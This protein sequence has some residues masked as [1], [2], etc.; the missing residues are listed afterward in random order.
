MRRSTHRFAFF[1]VAL[2][3]LLLAIGMSP[4][5]GA[6]S[7]ALPAGSVPQGS[8]APLNPAFLQSLVEVPIDLPVSGAVGQALG[9]RPGLLDFSYTRGMQVPG[10]GALA[11]PATY[12]LR[13]L[14]RV[15]SVKNQNPYGTC[16]TFGSLGS[17][18]SCLLPGETQD[19]SEDNMVLNH[20]FDSG[21]DPYNRGGNIWMSTAYLTR[22]SGPVYESEDAYGDS[23]TPAGLSPRK[24]VQEVNWIPVRG[25][26]LDNDN[27]KN[28][29]MVYGGADVS[30]GWYGD[31]SGSSY[32]NATTASYYYNGTGGTNHEVLLVGWDDNYAA[33]N[34]ATTPPGNGAFIVKNSWGTA[35]GSGGYFYASYYDTKFGR[36]NNPSAA[37]N[38]AEPTSNYTGLYQYDPLGFAGGYGYSSST[39]WFANVFT[40]QATASLSAVGFY[41]VTPGTSYEVYTG[42]SLATKTLRTS[43]SLS[44]M[45]YHTVTLPTPVA[46]TS[47]QPFVVAV[48]V[49]SP[50]T[51][52]PIAM[53]APYSNYSSTATAQPGQSYVSATG[54]SW[55]D[56]TTSIA[57]ANVC[58]KAYVKTSGGSA[59]TVTGFNP[60]SGPVGTVVTV[61]GTGLL[62]ATSVAFN[63]TAAP[64]FNVISATQITATVPT[65]ATTGTIAVTTPGGTA[66]SSGSFTVTSAAATL[67]VTSPNGGETWPISS[68]QTITW[69]STGLLATS[70]VKIE[71]SRNG[72]TTWTTLTAST[73]NDGT[74]PWTVS[75]TATTQARIRITSTSQPTVTDTSDANFTLG[76]G[77]GGITTLTV[78]AAAVTGTISPALDA[79]WY[80]FTVATAGAYTID[81]NAGTL[82]DSILDLYGPNSQTTFITEND[83][84][85]GTDLMAQITQTL[86]PGTYYVKATGYSTYTG[87]YTIRVTTPAAAATLT[88]T[89]PNGG[90]TWPISSAQT[91]T[92]TSTGLL[93]TSYVKI[94]LSRNGGTTWTTLTASTPNDG[95]HPWTVSGT[96]TTQARIRITSTSQPTVTDT[97]DANFTL[98]SGGGRRHHPHRQRRGGDRHDLSGARRGLVSVHGGHRRRLHHRHQRGHAHR[99]HPGPLRPQQSDH[100][101]HRERRLQRHRPHG[102]DHPDLEPGH[103]LRE[104]HRLFDLHRHL[105]HPGDHPRG[106]RHPH[107]HLPERGGDLARK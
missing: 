71:L 12:D 1:T 80:Q 70:Y 25:S 66:T 55:A 93:A 32:Y 89:S 99:Q 28:A 106:R 45:G 4:A 86:S 37:Y 57:N 17:L 43:G 21:G 23:Y 62:G 102:P 10:V 27:L 48:K 52:W 31:S 51:S 54:S 11:L 101:H 72:G 19:F 6:E 15:T 104:G 82:T 103:L 68:A 65:G 87:T 59:P 35:W 24:H 63:G 40:A 78:N 30:M 3:W 94:E 41:A 50:G 88:V 61:N 22:W 107:R 36:G 105:H 13:S 18:E 2:C 20:G 76:S 95:T 81:T 73:P 69:T 44:Y 67:T 46:V 58:L 5:A 39:G 29:I 33:S 74:H 83:D 34:F 60:T 98:G 47:G 75:G 92:W 26:A 100:L 49:T 97:S 91:I 8:A 53:E 16:W 56:L 9:S 85:S 96:A 90:E 64:T 38:K 42:S 84:Y 7:G 77:G 79:D 14:G